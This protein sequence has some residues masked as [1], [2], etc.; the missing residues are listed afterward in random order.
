MRLIHTADWHIGQNFY[1]YDRAEEH[2]AALSRLRDIVA[3]HRPEVLLISGDIFHN[4][5][6]SASSQSIL[7]RAITELRDAVPNM[8]IIMTAGNHDSASRHEVFSD[9]WRRLGVYAIGSIADDDASNFEKLIVELPTGFVVAVPY[10]YGRAIDD[11]LFQRL[12]D[13]VARRNDKGLPVVVM[14]HA[15]MA[16]AGVRQDSDFKGADEPKAL[17]LFGSGYDYLALGHVHH[18]VVMPGTEGRVRYSGSLIPV[19]FAEDF[20]HSVVL[21][22]TDAH[23]GD[24]RLEML[25]IP[26]P[27]PVINVPQGGFKPW[28]EAL[29]V[30]KT[31]D[32]PP[33]AYIRL[34]VERDNEIP[35]DANEIALKICEEKGLRFCLIHHPPIDFSNTGTDS[36]TF[37]FDEFREM[38][39]LDVAT[40][41]LKDKDIELPDDVL[42]LFNEV[43]ESVASDENL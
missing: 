9:A 43:V 26:A 30:L 2:L 11:G 36:R 29:N 25:S 28:K 1:G 15:M 12:L 33:S 5:Q 42:N 27:R 41:Y 40:L 39:P 13:E 24:I 23:G 20:T 3:H 4:P 17:E 22:E 19:S 14:A 37:S 8:S 10:V 38:S 21:A 35:A 32:F 16:F 18:P 34:C 6:P 31:S 7:T